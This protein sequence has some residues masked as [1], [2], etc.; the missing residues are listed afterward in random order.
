M[1]CFVC[2]IRSNKHPEE[3][4]P[5]I[6]DSRAPYIHIGAAA[7]KKK[8]KKRKKEKGKRKVLPRKEGGPRGQNRH[9]IFKL[10]S[11]NK[12]SPPLEKNRDREIDRVRATERQ[13]ERE[14][15]WRIQGQKRHTMLQFIMKNNG[16]FSAP[17]PSSGEQPIERVRPIERQDR[18]SDKKK[19]TRTQGSK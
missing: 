5:H 13:R 4:G 16:A 14:K 10:F 9:T 11:R 17:K 19:H 12:G 8:K 15:H 2:V 18:E 7:C 1:V 6:P 3:A